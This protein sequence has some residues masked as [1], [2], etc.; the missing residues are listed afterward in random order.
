MREINQRRIHPFV[1]LI[2]FNR[3]IISLSYS[4]T[5][6]LPTHQTLSVVSLVLEFFEQPIKINKKTESASNL[7]IRKLN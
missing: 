6:P 3:P 1:F 4:S 2:L 7:F 5:H